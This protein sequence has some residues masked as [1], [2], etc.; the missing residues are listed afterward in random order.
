MNKKLFP[1]ILIVLISAIY[2]CKNP[3]APEKKEVP[4]P[5]SNY[6][7]YTVWKHQK[8]GAGDS[9]IIFYFKTDKKV[10]DMNPHS[11]N[12]PAVSDEEKVLREGT[13]EVQGN[14][15]K[16]AFGKFQIEKYEG[17]F[18]KSEMTIKPL[19]SPQIIKF[20]RIG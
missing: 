14:L 2:S 4:K 17:D 6:L 16:I 1:L 13:Y 19:L 8:T 12:N 11:Y 7:Q 15:V 3:Q 10:L 5:K 20:F 9:D 18:Q